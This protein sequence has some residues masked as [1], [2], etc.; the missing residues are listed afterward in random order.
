LSA[1][2]GLRAILSDRAVTAVVAVAFV[3]MFG[4]GIVLPILPLYARSFG[5][6]Y[7]ETGVLVAAYAAARLV[8]DLAAGA[9]VDRWGERRCAAT[10]LTIVSAA[11]LLTGLAPVFALAVAFW[12]CAGAG[13]ALVLAALFSHLLRVVP[14][15]RMARTLSIFYGAF[16]MGFVGGSLLAGIIAAALGL[17]APLFFSAGLALAAAAIYL[18]FVPLPT[19]AAEAPGLTAEEVL[20]ERDVAVARR[21]RAGITDLLRTPGFVTVIVT[22]LAYL[23]IVAAVFDTLVPLFA[24]DELAMSTAAIGVIFSLALA[25]EFVV[26]YP[27][28]ALADRHGRKIVLVPALAALALVCASFGWAGTPLI[29]GL[30]MALSGFAFGFAGVPPAA[31]L[32]DIVPEERSGTGVGV[33]RFCGDIGFMLGPLLAGFTATA[34]G[35]E[36]AFAIAVVPTL[37]AFV[38][39]LRTKET[40]KSAR[41]AS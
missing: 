14:Q 27:A 35:F 5:V 11:S 28:G 24:K 33:F 4:A 20:V 7:T 30:L 19:R 16:N 40:L 10:G 26:L 25:T 8:V 41:A 22:N 9:A 29:L 12:A 39:A 13:S 31:M 32:A 23:W 1:D 36:A 15:A 38:L 17:A 2:A 21:G 37:A 18:R 3:L 34:F 6:G